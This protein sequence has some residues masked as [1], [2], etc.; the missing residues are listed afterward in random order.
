MA[1][2]KKQLKTKKKIKKIIPSG[3]AH[4][5]TTF[6]NTI[7]S[8]SNESGNVLVWSSAGAL[9]VKG[10]KKSRPYVAQLVSASAVKAAL[11]YGM[12]EVRVEVK[13]PGPGRDAAIKTIESAGLAIT[14]ISDVTPVA[15]NGVRPP[16]KPRG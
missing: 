1:K 4:I 10:S 15:H 11:N 2:Q 16:K 14:S 9:G 13:G 5:H 3:V 12:K 6:N 8:I 7:V